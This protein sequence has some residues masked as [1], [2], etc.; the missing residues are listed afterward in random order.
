MVTESRKGINNKQEHSAGEGSQHT[1]GRWEAADLSEAGQVAENIPGLGLEG[2]GWQ[3][4]CP[5]GCRRG[6]G[7][8]RGEM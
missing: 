2:L 7:L 1:A 4:D 3:V 6:V 5:A 8:A